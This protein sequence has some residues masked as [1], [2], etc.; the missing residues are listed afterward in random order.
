MTTELQWL[1]LSLLMTSLL[2]LPY[3]LDRLAVRGVGQVLADTNRKAAGRTRYG[4]SGLR[5]AGDACDR[6]QRAEV[7]L[8]ECRRSG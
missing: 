8:N 6:P 4:R 1:T 5:L 7:D 3:I 2:W